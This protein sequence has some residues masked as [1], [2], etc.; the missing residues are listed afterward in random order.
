[1]TNETAKIAELLRPVL[2]QAARQGRT[3]TYRDLAARAGVPPPHS[4]HK[5]TE[6]LEDLVREDHAEGR[7]L[8]AA[9]AVGKAGQPRPGFFQLLRQLGRYDGPDS[10]PEA[11]Q[12]HARELDAALSY[13]GDDDGTCR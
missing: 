1:M 9:V 12:W 6:A 7:P 11:G 3:L 5:T 13:W 8:L 4:I 2:R 10:G